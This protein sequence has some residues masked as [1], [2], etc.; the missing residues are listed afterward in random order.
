MFRREKVIKSTT[1]RKGEK[2][3]FKIHNYLEH[4]K[5]IMEKAKKN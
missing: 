4:R 1:T 5:E 2:M 3:G